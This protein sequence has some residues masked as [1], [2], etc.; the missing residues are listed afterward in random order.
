LRG[1]AAADQTQGE[2]LEVLDDGRQVELVA[3]AGEAAQPQ[4]LEAVVGLQVRAKRIS[5]RFLSSRDWDEGLCLHLAS[6]HIT[7]ILVKIARD[8]ARRIP[9][10]APR[11]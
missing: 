3:C 10:A 4:P 7:G 1:L 5:T 11:L 6:S 9:G 2:C 8:L